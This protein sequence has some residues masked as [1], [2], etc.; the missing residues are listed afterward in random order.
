MKQTIVV[1]TFLLFS[2]F[3]FAQQELLNKA[4]TNGD[5]QYTGELEG[6]EIQF[7]GVDDHE[8]GFR[9]T[10]GELG[11]GKRAVLEKLDGSGSGEYSGAT[12]EYKYVEGQEML[13][14]RGNGG[15]HLDLLVVGTLEDIPSTKAA[16]IESVSEHTVLGLYPFTSLRV[17]TWRELVQ[18]TLSE[19]DIMRNEIFA[20]HGHV[21]KTA[22]YRNHFNAQPWY[23]GTTN[24]ATALL[25]EIELLNVAQIV[26]VQEFL[27]NAN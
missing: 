11:N 19:L 3:T 8:G 27:Q 20:R 25:T 14:F 18:F 10:L 26:M 5:I 13:I 22:R 7:S 6:R 24:D 2:Q 9:F 23:K 1:A 21:F 4:W 17:L 16:V 12:A 15:K